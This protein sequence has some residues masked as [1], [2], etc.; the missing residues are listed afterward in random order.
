VQ[1][2]TRVWGE[3]G[4]PAVVLVHGLTG[5]GRT[6]WRVGPALAERGRFV[7]AVDLRGH[8]ASSGATPETTLDDLAADV[9]ETV[10]AVVGEGQVDLVGHS[11][12]AL[13]VLTAAGMS[14]RFGRVVAEDPP[15][16]D[17]RLE[18]VADDVLSSAAL[19]HADP[20]RF[21]AGVRRE[22]PAWPEQDL[23]NEIVGHQ[24]IE[25]EPFAAA[26]RG[27]HFE[28]LD[29]LERVEAPL[30][31]VLGAEERESRLTGATRREALS[32]FPASEH[33]AGHVVHRDDYDGYVGV[34]SDFLGKPD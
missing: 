33:D 23:E 32:R 10:D 9:L 12:G 26:L 19:A 28:L 27:M 13:T 16:R 15:D 1:L 20:E 3:P 7:V 24:E 17:L 5:T 25:A 29:L 8:G 21:I 11:L 34:L 18:R 14:D 22:N 31:L 2:S 6:W 30:L 4:R